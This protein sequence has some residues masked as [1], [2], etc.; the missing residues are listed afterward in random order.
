[1]SAREA[2]I[3]L[4]QVCAMA[5]ASNLIAASMPVEEVETVCGALRA[6][7]GAPLSVVGQSQGIRAEPAP[8]PYLTRQDS[9][10]NWY[11]VRNGV[12]IASGFDNEAEARKWIEDETK[13]P[14]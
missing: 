13:A 2:L 9:G 11:V 3:V 8:A 5:R 1:M 10:G 14:S 4:D 7:L 6:M 12:H